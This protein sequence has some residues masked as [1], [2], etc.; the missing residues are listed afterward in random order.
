[1]IKVEDLEEQLSL[2]D[3]ESV[4]PS[5]RFV[6]YQ[7]MADALAASKLDLAILFTEHD[8]VNIKF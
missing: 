5:K 7:S 2:N 8:E 6:S 1:M 3:S 4:S